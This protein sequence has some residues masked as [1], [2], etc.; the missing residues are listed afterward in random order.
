[1]IKK[2]VYVQGT[3]DLF[4]AGHVNILRRARKIAKELIVGVNTSESAK[5]HKG[6]YPVIP[7]LDRVKMLKACRYVDRV[8]KSDLTFNINKLRRY[9]IE[10]LVLGSDLKGKYFVGVSE[11]KEI[12]IKVV[13]FPYTKG[14]SS[15]K[16]KDEIRRNGRI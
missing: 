16:V 13:Y 12:G 14:V 5:R 9:K 3:W 6:N 7:Y 10:I 11:A 8:I 2:I 1:M 15:T 4:H